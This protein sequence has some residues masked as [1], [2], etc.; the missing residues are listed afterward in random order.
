MKML[1]LTL[2]ILIISASMMFTSCMAS[3]GCIDGSG[4]IKTEERNVGDFDKVVL[5]GNADIYIEQGT[6]QSVKVETDDNLMQYVTT[7]I[8]GKTLIVET[9]ENICTK[10]LN[11]HIVATKFEG[12]KIKGS[13]NIIGKGTLKTDKAAFVIDGSGDV[14]L[15]IEADAVK[16]EINGSGDIK[17]EGSVRFS[18]AEIKGSGDL[19]LSGLK[20]AK[21]EIKIFGSGDASIDVSSELSVEIFGSGD[22]VYTGNPSK[23][24]QNVF[25]SGSIHKK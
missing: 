25:G 7:R 20:T 21:T 10:K 14:D 12:A 16:S 23:V 22:V 9:K 19:K 6:T 5:S 2:A 18:E 3:L 1:N 8:N 24:D 17:I 15:S 4:N 11:I 13:G